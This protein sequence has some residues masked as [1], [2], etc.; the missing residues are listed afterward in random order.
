M[1]PHERVEQPEEPCLAH[2]GRRDLEYAAR[3]LRRARS[4][5]RDASK[6]MKKALRASNRRAVV[7]EEP[8]D[9]PH[10]L[11]TR[12]VAELRTSEIASYTRASLTRRQT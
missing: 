1:V 10:L 11:Y 9:L 6:Q 7:M 5:A 8:G 12:F 4:E 3:E 2:R